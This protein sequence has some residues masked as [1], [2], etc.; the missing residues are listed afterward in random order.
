MS[1]LLVVFIYCFAVSTF[2]EVSV[3]ATSDD[4]L[5][6]AEEQQW[7]KDHPVIRVGGEMDWAPFDF[8]NQ[9]GDYD[10][11]VNEFLQ[12]IEKKSG[13]KLVVET[14]YTWDELVT[15]FKNNDYDL[16]PATYYSKERTEYGIY[17][18]P[19]LKLKEFV[20]IRDDNKDINSFYDLANKTIAMPKGYTIIREIKEILPDVTILETDNILGAINA[21]LNKQAAALIEG[22]AVMNY[23]LKQ[24]MIT[25]LRGIAQEAFVPKKLHILVRKDAPLLQQIIQKSLN[26]INKEERDAIVDEYMGFS[27]KMD[28]TRTI[29]LTADEYRYLKKKK[30]ITM[31][32]DPDWLPFE[33]INEQGEHE[34]TA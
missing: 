32:V 30:V 23:T 21:V 15:R 18:E 6:T 34:G 11:L 31:C 28:S 12:L 8:V 20:Y 2:I 27:E 14:G 3:A 25:G 13:L 1:K 9:Y 7:I 10:G 24:N 33:H 17:T 22:Q 4:A 26:A 19:Y 16:L 5:F 29:K